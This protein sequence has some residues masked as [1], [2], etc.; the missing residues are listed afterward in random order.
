VEI[1]LEQISRAVEDNEFTRWLA[2]QLAGC[3]YRV[4]CDLTKL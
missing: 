2:L 4:W 1:G 3:G